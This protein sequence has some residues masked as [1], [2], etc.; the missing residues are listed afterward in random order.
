MKYM[1]FQLAETFKFQLA[2]AVP[3]PFQLAHF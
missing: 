3:F 2:A 1:Q